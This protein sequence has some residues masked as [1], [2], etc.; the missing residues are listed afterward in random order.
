MVRFSG[1]DGPQDEPAAAVDTSAS[2]AIA[3]R[4]RPACPIG[5]QYIRLRLSLA[6]CSLHRTVIN[7]DNVVSGPV[8]RLDTK[9]RNPLANFPNCTHWR[10]GSS[11]LASCRLP[12]R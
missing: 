8:D 9:A 7:P 2:M 10:G 4:T 1:W 5:A 3:H 12:A 11:G 6:V